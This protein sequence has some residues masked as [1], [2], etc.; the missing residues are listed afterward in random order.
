MVIVNL[1][2]RLEISELCIFGL[3]WAILRRWR[4]DQTMK[5]FMGRL[6]WSERTPERPALPPGLLPFPGDICCCIM[7]M[8]TAC[9]CCCWWWWCCCCWWWW[10]AI[11]RPGEDC[12]TDMTIILD[13]LLV[14]WKKFTF[15]FFWKR[16]SWFQIEI[17]LFSLRWRK[18]LTQGELRVFPTRFVSGESWTATEVSHGS[19]TPFWC[20]MEGLAVSKMGGREGSPPAVSGQAHWDDEQCTH[21]PVWLTKWI[22]DGW[23]YNNTSDQ[24]FSC[25]VSS[26]DSFSRLAWPTTMKH[27]RRWT[28]CFSS[29]LYI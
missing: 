21:W 15:F 19:C 3:S 22:E 10:W 20:W 29:S 28:E 17:D 11:N 2:S 26:F 9:C 7:L 14:F 27:H 12:I 24:L 5:A 4:R 8:A 16:R 23:S 25:R 18:D 1:P 13:W 6:M